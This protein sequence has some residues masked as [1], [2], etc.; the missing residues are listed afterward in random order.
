MHICIADGADAALHRL[1][2]NLDAYMRPLYP[3][4]S[5][6]LDSVEAMVAEG[7]QF[8]VA[9]DNDQAVGCIGVRIKHDDGDYGEIKRVYIE[10]DHRGL[11]LSGQLLS[12]AESYLVEHGISIARLETGIS[13]PEA[14]RFFEKSGFCQVKRF[15]AYPED[16]LSVFFEKPLPV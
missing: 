6:H 13:Q 16:P 5:N 14:L 11:G 10:P 2:D 4:E 7:S 15:G 3:D 8:F 1:V 9:W 12:E